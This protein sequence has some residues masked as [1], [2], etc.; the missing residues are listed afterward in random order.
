MVE[1]HLID[2]M[3]WLMSEEI[4]EVTSMGTSIPVKNSNYK[5]MDTITSLLK[6]EKLQLVR[7]QHVLPIRKI[8][9]IIFMNKKNIY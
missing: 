3:R 2:L 9:L 8:S 5:W 6:W 7:L 1:I 4:K